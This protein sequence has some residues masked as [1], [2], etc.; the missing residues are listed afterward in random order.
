MDPLWS[1]K[2]S[3][4]RD[5]SVLSGVIVFIALLTSL[6]VAY[7]AFTDESKR[8]STQ[9][10]E[11][12]LRIDKALNLEISRASYV[13]ESVG[14]QVIQRGV[15]DK[16][17]IA[18]MLRAFDSNN[19]YYSVFLWV[20]DDLQAVTS[21]RQ[22]VLDV[23]VDLS[24]RVYIQQSKQFP[25][26]IQIGK[27]TQ[28]RISETLVI[29]LAMGLTDHT[30]RYIGSVTLSIDLQN[31]T[32]N[33][34][35]YLHNND[36][37]FTILSDSLSI[38]ANNRQGEKILE[39]K[40]LMKQVDQ[41]ILQNYENS[42]LD[43]PTLFSSNRIFAF[44]YHSLDHSYV[45]LTSY[46]SDYNALR[47]LILPRMV[48]LMLV[49][50]FL[51]SLLWLVRFRVIYPVQNLA[52]ASSEIARGTPGVLVP[53]NGPLEI[54]QLS[55][56][57]QNTVDYIAE[58]KR[59]EEELLAKVLGLKTAKDTAEIS[60]QAKMQILQLLKPEIFP[61]LEDIGEISTLLIENPQGTGDEQEHA[62]LLEQLEHASIHLQEVVNEIFAL[63]SLSEPHL[64]A[65]RKPVDVGALVHKC[66]TLLGDTLDR[67]EVNVTIRLQEALPKLSINELHLMHVIMHLLVAC[68]SAIPAGG[69]LTIE[70]SLEETNQGTE[71]ALMFN[72]NASGLDT[73]QIA[74]SW[75]TRLPNVPV[76]AVIPKDTAYSEEDHVGSIILTKK[77]IN[78]H[79]GR[80]TV[81]NPPDKEAVITVYFQQ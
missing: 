66:V 46:V 22:G 62:L 70:A 11:E 42:L 48:Q 25:F 52:I 29:P 19:E 23:P 45:I 12:A 7:E 54:T 49:A 1:H 67:E 55:Q 31:L 34:Q 26:H 64:L 80:M 33:V 24:D 58:R 15:E 77:I 39:S 75:R 17:Q 71:F 56:Q 41:R 27:P 18:Q 16:T 78:L 76:N 73:Q 21:S 2:S 63:P 65:N 30:G 36:V 13:L 32:E 28:G 51:V 5:F 37:G 35:E 9:L 69:E 53:K 38:L 74:N 59:V 10:E 60:D 57:L 3:V 8:I 79:N 43:K 6:W 40:S 4:N 20:D 47:T 81:Q 61:A 72:D 44:Y 50:A 68:A 14:R